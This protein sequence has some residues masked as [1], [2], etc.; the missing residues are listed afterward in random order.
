MNDVLFNDYDYV[1]NNAHDITYSEIK[2]RVK[3]LMDFVSYDKNDKE[4]FGEL[5]ACLKNDKRLNVQ[6]LAYS[7]KNAA[8]KNEKEISRVKGM[9]DFDKSYGRT[10]TICGT[11]EV[12]RGPLAGPIAAGAVILDLN[13]RENDMLLGIKDSKKLS[14]SQREKLSKIIRERALY[15]NISL[16][17]S[18]VIDE[19][20]ISWCNNEVLKRACTGIKFRP[21]IVLSDGY[22][23]KNM[24]IENKYIIKGDAKSA[25]IA[26]ASIIAKVYRDKLMKEYSLIY[27]QYGFER[28]MGYG[29]QEH[30]EALRKYGPCA[31]HRISFLKNILNL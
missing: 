20:G 3:I 19:K 29:T 31:I 5:L 9:Y 8:V 16:L 24:N 7:L 27:P 10:L 2:D 15:Y 23:V 11:D 12:G 17:S 6:K 18:E 25:S 14:P 30:I 21:D 1:I 4:R 13:C 28:N 22:S 26:C